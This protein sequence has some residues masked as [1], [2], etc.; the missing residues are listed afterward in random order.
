METENVETQSIELT[1]AIV[2]DGHIQVA[3]SVVEVEP[4]V[5]RNLF[6]RNKAVVAEATGPEQPKPSKA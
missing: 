1:A 5:A 3:G 4:A 6:A 2:L